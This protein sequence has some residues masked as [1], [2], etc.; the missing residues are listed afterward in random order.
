[1]TGTVPGKQLPCQDTTVQ[2]DT[3]VQDSEP[4]PAAFFLSLQKLPFAASQPACF[5]S[6]HESLGA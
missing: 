2:E 5:L 4:I 6:A 3:T 1:M